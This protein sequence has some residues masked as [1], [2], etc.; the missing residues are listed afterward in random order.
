MTELPLPTPYT[1]ARIAGEDR[2]LF[3]AEQMREY[4]ALNPA[5]TRAEV[6]LYHDKDMLISALR[7]IADRE[8]WE[9]IDMRIHARAAL[10]QH[11]D[12]T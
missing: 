7:M 9:A 11:G 1:A 2:D 3:T 6:E 5:P 4:A 12:K 10:A 8:G